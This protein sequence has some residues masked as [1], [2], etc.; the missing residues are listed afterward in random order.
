TDIR[1]MS[2]ECDK[3]GGINLAQGVCDTEIPE[4][5]RAGVPAAIDAGFNIYTRYDGLDKLRNAIAKKLSEENGLEFDPETEIV[6]SIGSTGAFYSTG[7]AL[8]DPGDEVILFEPYYG[9]HLNSLLT[10][11]VV[12]K[13]V[14]MQAPDWTFTDADLEAAFSKRTKGIMICTPSNPC[15][16]VFTKEEIERV[17]ECARRHDT[18]VFTDEIYE[19]FLYDGREHVCPATLCDRDRT[20]TIS[21]YSKTFSITGWRVGYAACDRRWAGQIGNMND[22]AYVCSPSPLQSAVADGIETL[23]KDF[24]L[25]LGREYEAKRKEMC[26]ALQRAG[27]PPFVPQGA[28][29]V[30]ADSSRVPGNTSREKAMSLLDVTGVAA[31]PGE[32][33]YSQSDAGVNQLR[34]CFAKSEKDLHEACDR[35]VSRGA[36]GR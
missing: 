15:G 18:F 32:A 16:K 2:V 11:G 30:L 24:Q 17:S 7:L 19:Y 26:D 9:Y 28:Y 29:Y 5:V 33:F 31:V 23:G 34:F 1:S 12:P 3:R 10:L 13:F 36:Y 6:A 35:L 27:L 4:V 25:G 22:V 8:L 14:P 20:I 21:G